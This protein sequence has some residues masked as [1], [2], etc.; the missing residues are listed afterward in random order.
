MRFE[1]FFAKPAASGVLWGIVGGLSLIIVPNFTTNGY[2]QI[3]PYFFILL[4]AILTT[5]Y[6]N[7][8]PTNF[9]RLFTSGFLAFVISSLVLYAY[10]SAVV[11]PTSGITLVGHVWRFAVII[12][13][14][15]VSSS[16][17]SFLAKPVKIIPSN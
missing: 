12:G 8:T 2:L 3:V 14:A 10:V 16:I 6:I 1:T 11:N 13:L 7:K 17:I 9:K 4:A 5:K 15:T